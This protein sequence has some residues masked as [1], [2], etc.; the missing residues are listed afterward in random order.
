MHCPISVDVSEPVET[1]AATAALPVPG[2]DVKKEEVRLSFAPLCGSSSQLIQGFSI[3]SPLSSLPLPPP[4]CTGEFLPV[5]DSTSTPGSVTRRRSLSRTRRRLPLSM[6]SLPHLVP[7]PSLTRFRSSRLMRLLW[8]VPDSDRTQERRLADM[9]CYSWPLLLPSN[10]LE[11][12]PLR[13][14]PP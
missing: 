1:P 9:L 8:Q 4:R 12:F 10:P 14:R 6:R 13:P 7:R 11:K 3:H 2:V 5:L